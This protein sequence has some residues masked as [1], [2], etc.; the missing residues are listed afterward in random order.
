MHVFKI[1]STRGSLWWWNWRNWCIIISKVQASC[2]WSELWTFWISASPSLCML[3]TMSISFLTGV[4][5]FLKFLVYEIEKIDSLGDREPNL[6]RSSFASKVALMTTASQRSRRRRSALTLKSTLRIAPTRFFV[7]PK[8]F[9]LAY[10]CNRQKICGL[11][12]QSTL[13]LAAYVLHYLL[14]R[15]NLV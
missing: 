4:T 15:N 5:K 1:I 8:S 11:N 10:L 7:K 2:V 14:T 9:E 6:P 3:K 13:F 12:S